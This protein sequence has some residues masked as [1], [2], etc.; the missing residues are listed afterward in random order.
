MSIRTACLFLC[1]LSA[2][3]CRAASP[4]QAARVEAATSSHVLPDIPG[5]SGGPEERGAG[6]FRRSYARKAEATTVTLARF[7]MSAEQYQGWLRMS[8]AGFPQADLATG[9]NDGNGFYQC[10][11]DD[12]SRC[13]L[14]LQLRCGLHVEIRGQGIAR[15]ADADDILRGLG[16]LV[17][18]QGHSTQ[19]FD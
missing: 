5:F 14:L 19:S 11:A 9:S 16:H 3:A 4:S 17:S 18:C 1:A 13:N 15:R 12:S 2:L 6:F 8:T 7:P 10:A